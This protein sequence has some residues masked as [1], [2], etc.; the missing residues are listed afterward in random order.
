MIFHAY[1]GDSSE[2]N[3]YPEKI[4]IEFKDELF[5]RDLSEVLAII[6]EIHNQS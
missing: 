2:L 1:L 4:N 3:K 5:M 6:D